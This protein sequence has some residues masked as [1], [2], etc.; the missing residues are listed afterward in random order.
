MT[1]HALVKRK[2]VLTLTGG[3]LQLQR[4]RSTTAHHVNGNLQQLSVEK[5]TAQMREEMMVDMGIPDNIQK[6]IVES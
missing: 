4:P 5:A 2:S 1:N 3:R 6:A